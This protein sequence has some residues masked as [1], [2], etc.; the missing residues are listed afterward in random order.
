MKML[1]IPYV[2]REIRQHVQRCIR[3]WNSPAASTAE[4]NDEE[5]D[6]ER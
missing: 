6:E 3:Q 2:A 1:L 4:D 5:G